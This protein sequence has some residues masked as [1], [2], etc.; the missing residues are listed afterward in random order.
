MNFC[1]CGIGNGKG[2]AGQQTPIIVIAVPDQPDRYR[3]IDGYKRIA[4]LE[5]LGRD[6]V[7]VTI[8]P[9]SEA[10]ALV[11]NRS[12]LWSERA[13][14]LEQ[15]WLLREYRVYRSNFRVDDGLSDGPAAEG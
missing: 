7:E 11:L 1:G 9:L 2:T 12:L 14:A 15:G 6:T 10:E 8:W 3:V 5:Q 4:A 13:S